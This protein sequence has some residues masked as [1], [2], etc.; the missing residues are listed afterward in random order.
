MR[1][2]IYLALVASLFLLTSTSESL[3]ETYFGD[4]CW[5]ADSTTTPPAST[6]IRLGVYGMEGAHYPLYGRIH[7]NNVTAIHGNGE[8]V[9]T[10]LV[11]TFTES[12]DINNFWPGTEAVIWNAVLNLSTLNGTYSSLEVI[13]QQNVVEDTGTMTWIACP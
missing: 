12:G 10:N 7:G 11:M 13:P 9:G 6:L 5:Q 3:A 2:L 8:I 4:F 1:R